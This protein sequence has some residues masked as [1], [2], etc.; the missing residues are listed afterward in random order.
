M[1]VPRGQKDLDD[2][3]AALR[4]GGV[5]VDARMEDSQYGRFGWVTDPEG[6]RIELREP[7]KRCR[8]PEDENP[9]E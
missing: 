9:M 6:N 1:T 4:K 5:H 3:L 8:A 7:P 2:L